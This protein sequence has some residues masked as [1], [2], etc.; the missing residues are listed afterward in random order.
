[1]TKR[2]PARG[3]GTWYAVKFEDGKWFGQTGDTGSF[4]RAE[5]WSQRKYAL[6][7]AEDVGESTGRKFEIV[8]V[9]VTPLTSAKRNKHR[10][11]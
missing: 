8:P 11:R 9:R 3:S 6:G 10:T 5:L 2:K 1:M 7:E 4:Q